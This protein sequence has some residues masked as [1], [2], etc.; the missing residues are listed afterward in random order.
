MPLVGLGNPVI[1]I[2][3]CVLQNAVAKLG[4]YLLDRNE[5]PGSF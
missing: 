2:V 5:V 3:S 4:R 1:K